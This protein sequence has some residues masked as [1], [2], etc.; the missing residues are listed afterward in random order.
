MRLAF[1]AALL[2]GTA[3]LAQERPKGPDEIPVRYGLPYK[4]KAY[5]QGTPKEAL[6]SVIAAADKGEVSYLV[7]HLL[8]PAFVDGR[9]GDRARQFE[10]AVEAGLA[11][12]RD[13]QRQDP[14]GVRDEDRVPVEPDKFRARVAADA[15]SAAF[16]QLVRDVGE[17]LADDPEVLKDLRR[18]NRQGT[19]P[20]NPGEAAKV[21][22][23]EVRDRA[24][25]L[26]K[27]GDRW[28]VENRQS[29]EKVGDKK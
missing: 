18:F 24:V 6:E 22:L 4:A 5:P 10:P 7:A 19:F 8:D 20:E 3:A 25:Y 26:K 14:A 9:V 2:A 13:A 16:A 11:R 12:K 27:V 28:Y 17:K 15:K 23:P 1:A 29:E 21:G